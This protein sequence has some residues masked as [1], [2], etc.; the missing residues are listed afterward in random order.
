M[1]NSLLA[2]VLLL[3]STPSWAVTFNPSDIT[4]GK[5][6]NA[7]PLT[8]SNTVPASGSNRALF[9]G[10]ALRHVATTISAT[11]AGVSMTVVRSDPASGANI[12]TWLFKLANPATG[13]NNVVVTQTGTAANLICWAYPGLDV[14]QTMMT[15]DDDGSCSLSGTS[16]T[17]TLTTDPNDLLLD[18]A[19]VT[20]L[21][22][23]LTQDANQTD[24]TGLPD[25]Q[26]NLTGGGSS[27]SGAD[28][29]DMSWSWTGSNA[30]C[31]SAMSIQT[32]SSFNPFQRRNQ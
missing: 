14:D 11:Y 7:S 4:T 26:S 27:Q 1:N 24:L 9:V 13:A 29:G 23:N 28:G 3:L 6:N 10:C 17:V 5:I 16:R 18:V 31:L 8:F 19:G 32:V 12:T 21:S 15:R 25:E 2:F 30:N 22:V 20:A